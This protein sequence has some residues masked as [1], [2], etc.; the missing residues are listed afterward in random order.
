MDFPG[1]SIYMTYVRTYIY[2][3]LCSYTHIYIYIY[4]AYQLLKS[5]SLFVHPSSLSIM[6]IS[7]KVMLNMPDLRTCLQ[8]I[9]NT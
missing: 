1:G 4:N 9:Q 6:T 5:Q 2:A 8:I 3:V 7:P